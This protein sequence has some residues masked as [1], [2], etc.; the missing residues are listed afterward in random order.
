MNKMSNQT[1]LDLYGEGGGLPTLVSQE[2]MNTKDMDMLIQLGLGGVAGVMGFKLMSLARKHYG[3]DDDNGVNF[4][5]GVA[6]GIL[7]FW[8]VGSWMSSTKK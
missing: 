1:S 5:G 7:A 3:Y 6:L 2:K 4:L 8:G